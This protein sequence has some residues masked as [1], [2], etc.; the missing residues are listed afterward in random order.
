[1]LHTVHTGVLR[2]ITIYNLSRPGSYQHPP[3]H[4][5]NLQG[6]NIAHFVVGWL[7][8]SGMRWGDAEIHNLWASVEW[9]HP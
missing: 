7:D 1:M 8:A 9:G 5:A 4:L 6:R 3:V 2:D